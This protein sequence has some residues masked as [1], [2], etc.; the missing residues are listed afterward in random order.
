MLPTCLQ[1]IPNLVPKKQTKRDSSLETCTYKTCITKHIIDIRTRQKHRYN[2]IS[3]FWSV[4]FPR[5]C[6]VVHLFLIKY[7]EHFYQDKIW[8]SPASFIF[9]KGQVLW[10]KP[11]FKIQLQKNKLG[12]LL[13]SITL[14]IL[15][16]WR[17]RRHGVISKTKQYK[18][19][20]ENSM[21]CQVENISV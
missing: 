11:E 1:K 12:T 15:V 4:F 17:H 20:H 6:T 18:N 21:F 16:L 2:I 14:K 5:N 10:K 3:I 19:A 13:Q 8:V 9:K 7:I